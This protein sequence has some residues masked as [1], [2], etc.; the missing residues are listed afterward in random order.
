VG[1]ESPQSASLDQ[2]ERIIQAGREAAHE[3]V[4][5]NKEAAVA[6]AEVQNEA[7]LRNRAL[8][9]SIVITTL[10]VAAQIWFSYIGKTLPIPDIVWVVVLSPWFG[11]GGAKLTKMLSEMGLK[12]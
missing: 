2:T 4:E 8:T 10:I 11:V 1:D 7:S 12:K 5:T 6:L 3:L 9:F